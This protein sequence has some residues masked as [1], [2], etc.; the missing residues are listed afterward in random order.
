ME[1]YDIIKLILTIIYML[2]GILAFVYIIRW[3]IMR[4]SP[5]QDKR[6]H[7]EVVILISVLI[8]VLALIT[9]FVVAVK[10]YSRPIDVNQLPSFEVTSDSL[11]NGAW[12]ISTGAKHEN[13]CP[14]LHW[15][16][17]QDAKFYAVIMLDADGNNW[18]HWLIETE[19]TDITAGEFYDAASGYVGPYPPSGTH[20]YTIYVFA[21]KGESYSINAKLDQGGTDL[22]E[23]MNQLNNSPVTDYNNIL[24]VGTI[25]GTFRAE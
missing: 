20:T 5:D 10:Q 15:E 4:K 23:L 24:A 9:H 1:I 8:S 14:S 17:Y 7:L 6:K 16:P 22:Q 21:L 11:H 13:K 12:D 18:L 25:A 3:L 19:I 2:S